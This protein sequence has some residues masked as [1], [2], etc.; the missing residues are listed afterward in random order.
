VAKQED[1][2]QHFGY[3]VDIARDAL[4]S[5]LWINAG[6]AGALIA[7]TG[8]ESGANNYTH[9]IILFGIGAVLTVASYVFGYFSQLEYGN[10]RLTGE[11]TKQ[12]NHCKLQA[13]AITFMLIGLICAIAGMAVA[14]RATN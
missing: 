1:A 2:D 14:Y 5:L 11:E 13:V 9:A 10:Y 12:K 4:K 3:A 6:A 8:K 7:L